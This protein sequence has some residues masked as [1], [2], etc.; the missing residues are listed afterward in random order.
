MAA[1]RDNHHTTAKG[2]DEAV[3]RGFVEQFVIDLVAINVVRFEDTD[4]LGRLPQRRIGDGRA[5]KTTR[6]RRPPA[7]RPR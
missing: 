5:G 7:K 4:D 6:R 1:V 3:H 2:V